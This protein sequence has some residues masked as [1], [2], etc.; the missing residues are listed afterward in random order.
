MK[1]L[2]TF[3][4]LILSIWPSYCQNKKQ[5]IITMKKNDTFP[6]ENFVVL[7]ATL[8]N[9]KPVIGSFNV[10]YEKYSYKASYPWCLEISIGLDLE[11]V[12][13]DGLPNNQEES[14]IVNKL[15][16]ELVSEIK[17]ITTAHYIGHLF[18][19]TFLDV[20]IYLDDPEKVHNFLQIQTN[21]E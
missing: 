2:I 14:S 9:N 7:E 13:E 3:T 6:K 10:A 1:L 19:D 16:D 18:N 8:T 4:I 15:E 11:N 17:K 20:Y 5:T 12:N 21:K